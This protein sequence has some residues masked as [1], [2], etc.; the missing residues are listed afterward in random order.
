MEWTLI[1]DVCIL[2]V[3]LAMA[4]FLKRKI[5]LFQKILVPN[6]I[7]AGFLGF[8][9]GP[10][11]LKLIPFDSAEFAER[12]GNMVYHLM[13]VGFIALGLKQREKKNDRS[14]YHTGIFIVSSY[15]VQGIIGFCITL[16]LAFT[17]IPDLFAPFGLLLPLSFGQGPGQAFSIGSSWAENGFSN[18]G[19]VGLT[20]G[21]FGFLWASLGGVVY[22]NI[23]AKQKQK[24]AKKVGKEMVD[25]ITDVDEAGEIPL[26]ESIDRMS[27]QMFLIGIIYLV[28]YL[29]IKGAS[30]AL[31]GL[32]DFGQTFANLL[33]GFHFIIGTLYAMLLRKIFDVSKKTKMMK[34]NYPNN[35]LLQRIAGAAFDYMIV[36]AITAISISVFKQ[37]WIPIMLTTTIGGLF[38]MWYCYIMAK[39]IYKKGAI[40]N[41]IGMYGMMTGTISTGM[42]LLR[43]VDPNFKSGTAENLVLGSG[44][45]LFFG[46]PLL[47]IITV[48][49]LGVTQNNPMFFLY[50]MLAF[51]GYLL[52]LYGLLYVSLRKKEK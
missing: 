38:T 7:I 6:A 43:E 48:P 24:E 36:A 31:S 26:S 14:A 5:G 18:G 46:V 45:G 13:G 8:I 51:I 15:L 47:L 1:V 29:T 28:T 42:A 10:E 30:T 52:L 37:Y 20:M 33:V 35:F 19:K 25:K 21:T 34:R 44:V 39:K 41:A 4:T 3:L 40:E 17:F 16:I 11:V 22:I 32:G 12:L 23:L 9:V 27:V 49:V 50:G 2:S